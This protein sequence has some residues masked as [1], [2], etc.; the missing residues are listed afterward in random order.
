MSEASVAIKTPRVV[1]SRLAGG[2]RVLLHL[3]TGQYHE[4]NTIGSM[5]WDLLDGYRDTPEIAAE[6]G[7]QVDASPGDLEQIVTEFITQ[8]RERGLVS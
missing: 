4:L 2:E 7:A 1:H 6:V 5:I 8:L 3:E